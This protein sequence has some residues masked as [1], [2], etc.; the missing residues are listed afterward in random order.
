MDLDG[1]PRQMGI[2]AGSRRGGRGGREGVMI[3][4]VSRNAVVCKF[5]LAPLGDTRRPS[6]ACLGRGR[7]R[8]G[9][10]RRRRRR[11]VGHVADGGN[12][13]VDDILRG[14]EVSRRNYWQ[15]RKEGGGGWFLEWR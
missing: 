4:E 2:G 15:W 8:T 6:L 11:G 10:R 3:V 5:V 14:G 1:E 13:E 9:G 7:R 12:G